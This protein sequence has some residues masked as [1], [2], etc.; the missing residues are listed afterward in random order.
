MS[1]R[2]TASSHNAPSEASSFA[3]ANCLIAL[4]WRRSRAFWI[5]LAP[6]C[7]RAARVTPC[8]CRSWS[9]AVSAPAM[10]S[11]TI[12]R[13]SSAL[14]RQVPMIEQCTFGCM[15]QIAVRRFAAG[16]TNASAP[17]PSAPIPSVMRAF[18]GIALRANGTAGRPVEKML[19]SMTG[20]RDEVISI[21]LYFSRYSVVA[22]YRGVEK[23]PAVMA[24]PGLAFP[25]LARLGLARRSRPFGGAILTGRDGHGHEI[26][27]LRAAEKSSPHAG[28]PHGQAGR[29]RIRL[30]GRRSN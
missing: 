12:R 24:W 28:I 10:S 30:D 5:S 4:S 20:A 15:S 3:F 26:R 1:P 19:D 22:H 16:G 18:I 7:G 11:L 27:T 9:P 2:L 13:R 6:P 8:L 25:R 14:D 29:R 23:T 17:I 21:A